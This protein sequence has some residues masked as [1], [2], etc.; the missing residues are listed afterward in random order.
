MAQE[1][2]TIDQT[3][4]M[5]DG[6]KEWLEQVEESSEAPPAEET[7]KQEELLDDNEFHTI[8]DEDIEIEDNPFPEPELQPDS[9]FSGTMGTLNPIVTTS[10]GATVE[11]TPI[12]KEKYL[13]ALLLNKPVLLDI[14]LFD[15]KLKLTCRNIST[16]EYQLVDILG[17]QLFEK[18]DDRIARALL[19]AKLHMWRMAMQILRLNNVPCEFLEFEP[20]K[21]KLKEHLEELSTQAE[22]IIGAMST[23]MYNACRIGLNVF[24]TKLTKLDQLALARDFSTP[25]D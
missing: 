7:S 22:R 9:T 1:E 2:Q 17:L 6:V 4:P 16:Y 24:H 8:D 25:V 18:Y 3:S 14:S 13:R 15:D 11:I 10:D 23:S 19:P 5:A 20:E 12:D 21:G